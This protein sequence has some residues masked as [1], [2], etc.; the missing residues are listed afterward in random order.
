MDS[1]EEPSWVALALH[2]CSLT[3]YCTKDPL[4]GALYCTSIVNGGGVCYKHMLRTRWPCHDPVEGPHIKWMHRV[5]N[6]ASPQAS[7]KPTVQLLT[8]HALLCSAWEF[9]VTRRNLRV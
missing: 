7:P 1:G 9:G 4:D 2:R 5:L 8:N 6:E 3:M